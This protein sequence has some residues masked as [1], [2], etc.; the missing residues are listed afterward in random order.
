MNTISA[1]RLIWSVEISQA[2]RIPLFFA[3][4]ETFG[5]N[6]QACEENFLTNIYFYLI[7][8]NISEHNA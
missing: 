2:M 3:D 8:N 1:S 6:I 4:I 7:E 5:S